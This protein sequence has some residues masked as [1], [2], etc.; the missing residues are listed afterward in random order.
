VKSSLKR[1]IESL[2]EEEFAPPPKMGDIDPT[3]EEDSK[4]PGMKRRPDDGMDVSQHHKMMWAEGIESFVHG[5]DDSMD[6]LV[7]VVRQR[8]GFGLTASEIVNDLRDEHSVE[9]IYLA[10]QAAK[11]LETREAIEEEVL[12]EMSAI[13][14]GGAGM[15]STGKVSATSGGSA[16][17]SNNPEHELMWSGD[18]PHSKRPDSPN[19]KKKA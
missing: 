12:D 3:P 17:K 14:G 15:V 9:D 6:Q 5:E 1:L 10:Y 11:L 16:W 7:N 13:G 2:V 8:I 4:R 18:E 19:A